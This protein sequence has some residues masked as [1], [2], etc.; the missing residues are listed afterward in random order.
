MFW[1]V[2]GLMVVAALAGGALHEARALAGC[3]VQRVV[4]GRYQAAVADLPRT[5]ALVIEE[6]ASALPGT[7]IPQQRAARGESSP[8]IRSATADGAVAATLAAGAGAADW[9][10]VDP[11]LLATFE[12]L[13]HTS[14]DSALDLWGSALDG[15]LTTPGWEHNIRGHLGEHKVEAQLNHWADGRLTMPDASNNPG[16]D[17]Q[18]DDHVANV[19]VG[20]DVS[21]IRDHLT[22]HPD[23]PVIVNAD[24]DGLPDD[25][26]HVDLS[27]PFDTDVLAEHSIIVADGLLLSDLQDTMADAFGAALSSFGIDDVLDTA[28]DLGVPVLGTAVRVVRSGIRESKLRAVHGDNARALRNIGT[29]VA[30]TGGG[31]AAGGTLGIGLGVLIDALSMGTTAGFGTMVIGPAIGAFLGGRKGSQKATAMRMRRLDEA[32]SAASKAV[33]NYDETATAAIA[34]VNQ[35]WADEVVPQAERRAAEVAA[36]LNDSATQISAQAI[37]DL[38]R[39]AAIADRRLSDLLDEAETRVVATRTRMRY[40]LLVHHRVTAWRNAAAQARHDSDLALDVVAAS[41][42]GEAIVRQH[43]GWITDQKATIIGASAVAAA[44]LRRRAQLERLALLQQLRVDRL[45]LERGLQAQLQPYV[46]RIEACTDTVRSEL[47]ATGAQTQAWVD[48][49]FPSRR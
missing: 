21:A 46:A 4:R 2:L 49:N 12:Q 30:L 45:D 35:H 34:G 9:L 14:I 38:T 3:D 28:A 36:G 23:I 27:Q 15:K 32:R 8:G 22:E 42:G 33:T 6:L 1:T 43:L 31:V 41:P 29:D 39:L 7:A 10:H 40:S 18:L 26:F 37:S 11:E 48:E 17:L 24:M 47:V 25:A 13:T 5:D 16:F 20:A 44:R 19:K